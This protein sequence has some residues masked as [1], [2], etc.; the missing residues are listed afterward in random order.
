MPN[1]SDVEDELQQGDRD[2][3]THPAGPV[4]FGPLAFGPQPAGVPAPRCL[5]GPHL[6]AATAAGR[7]P[8]PAAAPGH[9]CHLHSDGPLPSVHLEAPLPVRQRAEVAALRA[10]GH[11]ASAG[12]PVPPREPLDV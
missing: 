5:P 6:P 11:H 9:L 12:E 4:V 3:Q 8:A 2:Q 10:G 1:G 7:Q